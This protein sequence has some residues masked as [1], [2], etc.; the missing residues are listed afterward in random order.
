MSNL[1][2][3]F[4]TNDPSVLSDNSEENPAE[5]FEAIGTLIE[6]LKDDEWKVRKVAADI[7]G[8]LRYPEELS[9]QGDRR[10]V[11]ALREALSDGSQEVRRAAVDALAR[12]GGTEVGHPL[13]YCL[14]D[15]DPV[16]R[17]KAATELWKVGDNQVVE[18]LLEAL[19]DPSWEVQMA[20]ATA[21]GQLGDQR[22]VKPLLNALKTPHWQLRWRAAAALGWLGDEQTVKPLL[23]SLE[24]ETSLVR[25]A[26]CE[27][28]GRLQAQEAIQPLMKA[29]AD[30]D[31][32]VREM[33]SMA[34]GRIGEPALGQL[35]KGLE[36]PAWYIRWGSATALGHLNL[37]EAP[38]F[39]KGALRDPHW[40]V[41]E[42][43]I[44]ALGRQDTDGSIL[45]LLRKLDIQHP[46][47]QRTRE[48]V[49]GQ[50]HNE[51]N[52]AKGDEEAEKPDGADIKEETVP[53]LMDWFEGGL[54]STKIREKMEGGEIE[55]SA[56]IGSTEH[57]ALLQKA[58]ELVD[59]ARDAEGNQGDGTFSRAYELYQEALTLNPELY[60]AENNWGNALTDQARKKS[61]DEASRLYEEAFMHYQQ[62]LAHEE[63]NPVALTNWGIALFERAKELPPEQAVEQLALASAKYRQAIE[64]DPN[65]F[66]AHLNWGNSLIK[67]AR[68]A[69]D[70][71]AKELFQQ[72]VDR[73]EAALDIIPEDHRVLHYL[74]TAILDQ[75]KGKG[76]QEAKELMSRA[77]EKLVQAE[78][79]YPG[80]SSY[81]LGCLSAI[82]GNEVECRQ[83][84]EKGAE[85]NSLPKLEFMME[86]PDLEPVR[87]AEWFER[88]VNGALPE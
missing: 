36:A 63:R 80:R 16:I 15:E 41:Q 38:K 53:L 76:G 45:H 43:T 83:W 3:H 87:D 51:A 5:R 84:L 59:V 29:L 18:P 73:Y 70:D 65:Y 14:S 44:M 19:A 74:G 21:L 24:D 37:K 7:L 6:A 10:A 88:I 42:A 12:I 34:L 2:D 13:A 61:G 4:R 81:N 35:I 22:A 75:A 71:E 25:S 1:I 52:K 33:A 27:S 8:Q 72:A 68:M 62:A 17:L 28:L 77:R 57:M 47:V 39:L 49:M 32:Q 79:G 56:E 9:S 69:Q 66:E 11:E 85:M 60:Q 20:V 46:V 23:R 31:P 64:I 40:R 82:A 54:D 48:R 50:I 67:L 30:G 78:V 26:A 86:D 58:D 55:V